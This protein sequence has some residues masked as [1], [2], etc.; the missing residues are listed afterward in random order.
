MLSDVERIYLTSDG[1]L[2]FGAVLGACRPNGDDSLAELIEADGRLRLRKGKPVDLDRYLAEVP[3]L[4]EHPDALDAA[5]DVALRGLSGSAR[6]TRDAVESLVMRYPALAD[7]IR[8]TATL[9][10]AM[11]STSG[12]RQ[13]VTPPPSRALPCD[14]GPRLPSGQR[15]YVLDELLGQGSFG[16]VYKATD[17]QL[18]EEGH[19]AIVAIKVLADTT[20]TA[21]D[22]Q[23][24]I[25]EATKVRRISHPNVV[26]VLDRGVSEDDED[27]I[28]YE[29]VDGGDLSDLLNHDKELP[30]APPAAAALLAKIALGVHAAHSAG[31]I[32]CDLKPSNIMR[33]AAGEPKVADFGIAVRLQDRGAEAV[34][35]GSDSRGP[36]GN[37][38]FISPEQFRGED[39]ALSVPSDVYALGG[40]LFYLLTA[41][42]PNGATRNEI[43]QTHA[44][45]RARAEAPSPSA[46]IPKLDRDLDAICRRALAP[47]PEDRYA[48]AAML[49]DDLDRWLGLQPIDWTR[50]SVPRRTKLWARRKPALAFASVVILGLTIAGAAI[51]GHFAS[52]ANERKIAVALAEM[53]VKQEEAYNAFTAR[54]L[55]QIR[56]GLSQIA[57]Q[58]RFL[59]DMLITAWVCEYIYGPQALGSPEEV[60]ETWA[61]R[62][63]AVRQMLDERRN[64]G[65]GETIE[66]LLLEQ[67]LAFW[68]VSAGDHAEAIDLLDHNIAAWT[69]VRPDDP[70]VAELQMIRTC[71]EVNRLSDPQ[72]VFAEPEARSSAID[73]L[74]T[75]LREEASRLERERPRSPLHCLVLRFLAETHDLQGQPAEAMAIRAHLK[76]V[77]D[78]S[79]MTMPGGAKA[80]PA[81]SG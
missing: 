52:V 18:S 62:A 41:R 13:R 36:I 81:A 46:I 42:L 59:T 9:N 69:S 80:R 5:I 75:T 68:R 54:I 60:N 71:A 30:L 21:A 67:M 64:E 23:R 27:F 3:H 76:T 70:M 14:F 57:D 15:R 31:V 6:I 61:R 50:P 53:K 63:D 44:R 55:T 11:W 2:G 7:T 49:A 45:E 35:P 20:R 12:L 40:I 48:S 77:L 47:Q 22:R 39:A 65:R 38:A 28:V 78:D 37:I 58:E 73:S 34:T 10:A 16:Q 26:Q 19:R 4:A 32:H 1:D 51:A 74:Q 56:T 79:Q 72:T 43:A 8:E 17:R 25:E 24:L 66:T 29:Y 33:T